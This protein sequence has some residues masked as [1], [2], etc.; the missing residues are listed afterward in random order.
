MEITDGD[1]KSSLIGKSGLC[2]LT[3]NA[4]KQM[5]FVQMLHEI[6]RKIKH[7]NTRMLTDDE[8]V[9]SNTIKQDIDTVVDQNKLAQE[10][11]FFLKVS[12]SN[13]HWK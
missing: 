2:G 7:L 4:D 5:T 3:V 6:Q 11:L 9:D 8:L 12:Q 13:I 10:V 1:L